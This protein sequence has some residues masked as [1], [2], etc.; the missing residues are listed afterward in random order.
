[1]GLKVQLLD[2][3]YELF[4][5]HFGA[6]SEAREKPGNRAATRGVLNTVLRLLE[7]GATH[8]GVATDHVVESFRNDM[9]PG[10]KTSAGM[11]PELLEQFPVVEDALRA[12]GVLVWAMV[13]L[14]A[15]DALASAAVVAA[16]DPAVD[17]VVIHTPDKDLAQCVRA[18]K[19]VQFDKRNDRII[20]VA[21]VV[22]K[23][24]VEPASIPD[25]LALVGDSADGFPGL[26]GWGA[27][28]AGAVLARYRRLEDIPVD[29]AWDL[30]VRG[31]ARLAATLAEQSDLAFLFRDLATLRVDTGLL[32]SVD[33]LR[34][35]GAASG[36]DAVAE[37]LGAPELAER[38]ATLADKRT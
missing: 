12:M 22:E 4:R 5:Q 2:G 6:P 36:F 15:D 8:V 29:G 7:D 17:Q 24:G 25:Y 30:N 26:T 14:E 27:K 10:Y 11:P 37:E 1:M 3:T 34:W 28:S 38:A 33:D 13:E 9:W 20:D 19:V 23:F 21:G 32:P 31:A 16:G 35:I 18:G